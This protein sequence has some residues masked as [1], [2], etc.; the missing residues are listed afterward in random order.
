MNRFLKRE[1]QILSVDGGGIRGIFPTLILQELERR[2]S[3]RRKNHP[4]CRAFDL[5]AGTST[6]SIIALG[7]SAPERNKGRKTP[8]FS[9][10]DLV[11][12]Y[13]ERGLEIFPRH[14]FNELKTVRQAFTEKYNSGRFYEILTE[15]LGDLSLQDALTN[16]LVTTYDIN[17]NRPL[18]MKKRPGPVHGREKDPNFYLRDAIMG[19]SAA[20][21]Y[22]EPVQVK[23]VDGA[24]S[25]LLVDG[26]V[27]AKN[28]AMC[29]LVEAQKIY[30]RARHFTI[31]SLGTGVVDNTYSYQ[32]M[33]SWGFLEWV[34]P[35]KGIPL[36]SIMSDGQTKCVNYQLQYLPR[37]DYHR[38]DFPIDGCSRSIDDAEPENLV[39]LREKAAELI[40]ENDSLLD[41]MARRLS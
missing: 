35:S 38:I 31:L 27:F 20:P 29:A 14:I 17:H 7:L 18:I 37:V 22:F 26:S 40:Q 21:T 6:G 13:S 33:K 32:Q 11:E 3:E 1:V 30:P 9:A 19:S 8:L 4:L 41:D 16:V 36:A 10:A 23:T 15:L 24:S 39:C 2:I 12:I 28:P 34:L 5:M 25:H